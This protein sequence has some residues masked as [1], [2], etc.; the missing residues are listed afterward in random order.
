MTSSTSSPPAPTIA[1]TGHGKREVRPDEVEF[2]F[3]LEGVFPSVREAETQLQHRR[4]ALVSALEKHRGRKTRLTSG[5]PVIAP[6]RDYEHQAYV[7]KGFKASDHLILRAPLEP[8][9]VSN[10]LESIAA[11][12]E[13]LTFTVRYRSKKTS[14][15]LRSARAE[16]VRDARRKATHFAEAAGHQLGRLLRLSDTPPASNHGHGANML[17]SAAESAPVEIDPESQAIT[18]EVHGVWELTPA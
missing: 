17:Y 14:A 11:Q 3:I 13:S 16:A 18:A 8:Y 1:V 10:V 9:L 2:H 7:F 12:I 5:E 15:A 6:Q 4:S